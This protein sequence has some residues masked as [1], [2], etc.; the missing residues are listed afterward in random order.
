M[1]IISRRQQSPRGLSKLL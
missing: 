1:E